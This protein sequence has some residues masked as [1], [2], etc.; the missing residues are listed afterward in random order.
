MGASKNKSAQVSEL[1]GILIN[2]G[3][4]LDGLLANGVN[5]NGAFS[6]GALSSWCPEGEQGR[7]GRHPATV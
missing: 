3:K 2:M 7:P 5:G 4:S 6:E 1:N